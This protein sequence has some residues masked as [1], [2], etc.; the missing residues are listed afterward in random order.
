M[1]GDYIPAGDAQFH[2]WQ[3]NF[4]T[5]V[6]AHLADLG[7]VAG[8][9]VDLNATAATWTTDYPA[10]TAAQTAARGAREAKDNARD[11]FQDV[12]R[13][14]VRRLQASPD[15]DDSERA[16]ASG[17]LMPSA[18][19]STIRPM[20]R[21]AAQC[22]R[23]ASHNQSHASGRTP[24]LPAATGCSASRCPCCHHLVALFQVGGTNWPR[25]C[26]LTTSATP[27]TPHRRIAI[28]EP[29][30]PN[31]PPVSQAGPVI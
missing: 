11:A 2:A 18:L 29:S 31:G 10:H 20:P 9:V 14:L 28:Y 8:D 4:I 6:N 27:V 24:Y 26:A 25:C 3:N 7:L 5:Y 13:P 15:V 23:R 22:K 1:A 30:M 19:H 17:Y 21:T 12:I 16:A